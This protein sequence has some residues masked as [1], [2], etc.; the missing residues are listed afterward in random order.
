MEPTCPVGAH[1][2]AEPTLTPPPETT[3]LR[4]VVPGPRRAPIVGWR[5][6]AVRFFRNPVVY[7]TDL[8]DTY[9]HVAQ[10]A[11]GG[12][13]PLFAGSD[14]GARATVFGFGGDC[15]RQ[16]LGNDKVFQTRNPPGPATRAFE[17]LSTN[18]LF[19]NGERHTHLRQL[20]RPAFTRESLRKYHH[21]MIA[22]ADEM[23][24]G[25]RGQE[26]VDWNDQANALAL[27]VA[28]KCFYGLDAT[29]KDRGLAHL[30]N[31]MLEK[32]FSP[33]AF[34]KINLPGTPYRQL[35]VTMEKIVESLRRE[36]ENKRA[37]GHEGEDILS[38]LVR[39]HDRDAEQLTADELIGNAFV[40]FFGGHETTSQALT[41]TLFLLA[42]H[43]EVA[44]D[45]V[46][47]L[48]AA[49]GG[50]PPTYA[51]IYELQLLDRVIKESLRLFP[52]GI[53]F[54]RVATET[55][56]LGGYE[57][58][59]GSEVVYSP[60]VT[61]RDPQIFDQPLRFRPDRWLEIKPTPFEYL[62]F[63][64]RGRTCL[65]LAFAGMQLRTVIP[66]LLQRFTPRVVPGTTVNVKATTV[67]GPSHGMPMTL[68]PRDE[69][70]QKTD[71]VSGLV[72]QMV[73]L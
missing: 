33:A 27:R 11:E 66:M 16:I 38:V 57:I 18:I 7:L 50:E 59:A 48:D 55:T 72:R 54:P 8:F 29:A 61:H 40:L 42:Q 19:I 46:D 32:L 37:A 64:A 67:M 53:M 36:I 47:E 30:M 13:S 60:Y 70:F 4:R 69:G 14:A 71:D 12:N 34:L 65:G 6:N 73:E 22:F 39:E 28:S 58:P 43:P 9:G 23:L 17:L 45:L 24:T 62:P 51:Q 25:W 63:G 41:W 68:H 2:I 3:I 26:R 1:Q 49:L 5:G 56:E 44:A 10:L 15:N 20:L 35:V 31:V 52:P 21:H